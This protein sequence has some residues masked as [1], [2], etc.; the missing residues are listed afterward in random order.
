MA[1]TTNYVCFNN[2]TG[3][4][5]QLLDR[6]DGSVDAKYVYD[7]RGDTVRNTGTYAADNPLR[8]RA[9]YFD[10]EFDYVDTDCDGLYCAADATC[11]SPRL[12]RTVTHRTASGPVRELDAIDEVP[13]PGP[14]LA[15]RGVILPVTPEPWGG[16]GLDEPPSAPAGSAMQQQLAQPVKRCSFTL[17]NGSSG[18]AYGSEQSCLENGATEIC[19]FGS[20]STGTVF[21]QEQPNNTWTVWGCGSCTGTCQGQQGGFCMKDLVTDPDIQLDSHRCV[22]GPPM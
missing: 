17:T 15:S 20:G 11:H 12:G 5:A 22:C 19:R 21:C 1:N 3:S 10:S 18:G 2:G 16:G 7:T 9:M 8:Y 4:V 14:P 6:S 13:V